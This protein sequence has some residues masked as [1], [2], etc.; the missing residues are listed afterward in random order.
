MSLLLDTHV[1]L[2]AIGKPD[3]LSPRVANLILDSHNELSVSTVSLWEIMIKS[4]LGKLKISPTPE[5]FEFQLAR[6]GVRRVLGISPSHIY[7]LLKLPPIHK[8]PFDRLLAAQC[9][10][11]RLSLVTA[12][13]VLQQYPIQSIW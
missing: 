12:D 4:Q 7:T 13:P 9:V 5:Y 1:L 11:E 3:R 6:L 10:A 8:D 2:W